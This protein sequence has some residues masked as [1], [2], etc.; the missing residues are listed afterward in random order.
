MKGMIFTT[1]LEMV[2]NKFSLRMADTII[3]SADLASGGSYTTLGTYNHHEMIQL[4]VKLSEQT[5]IP[6]SDLVRSF[7]EY[8][9]MHLIESHPAFA[10]EN[11]TVFAFLLRVD[12]YIH[13]EV[14]KLYPEAELPR[15]SY[16]TS[17]PGTLIMTYRSSRPF[18]D[19]AEGL[20]MGCIQHYGE[21]IALRR[22][23]LEEGTAARF[24]L[25]ERK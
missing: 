24:I 17:E 9:F 11:S 14:N 19:L 20:I 10:V 18:A 3:R 25:S 12:K 1:F 13:V 22:E 23:D 2:E 6:A 4:V 16:D 15:F 7:G 21:E 8:L 5:G